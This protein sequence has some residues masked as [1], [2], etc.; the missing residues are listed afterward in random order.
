[1]PDQIG[2]ACW[3]TEGVHLAEQAVH[4]HNVAGYLR[5]EAIIYRATSAWAATLYTFGAIGWTWCFASA[6]TWNRRLTLLSIPL[7]IIFLFAGIGPMLPDGLRPSAPAIGI[8]NALGFL[9]MQW[10]FLEVLEQVLRRSRGEDQ[11]GKFMRWRAPHP[12]PVGTLA[13]LF[14]NSR[15]VQFLCEYVPRIPFDS[16]ITDVIYINYLIEIERVAPIV[17]L[18]LELRRLGPEGRYALF[19]LL[20]YRHGRLGPRISHRWPV[21]LPSAIQSNWRIHVQDPR[22]Q[23]TGIHFVTNTATS[24]FV[25]IGGRLMLEAMP[26]HLLAGAVLARESDG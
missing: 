26:M 22:T 7:W 12:S 24:P 21:P 8:A 4:T 25:S 3:I 17:P 16:D 2:Q 15:V 13:T 1:M 9:L 20:T 10:W 5:F 23:T 6:G 19:T 14:A 11:L 18:G